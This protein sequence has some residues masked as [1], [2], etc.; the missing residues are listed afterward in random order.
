MARRVL[1]FVL[2]SMAIAAAAGALFAGVISA[3]RGVVEKISPDGKTLTVKFARAEGT[4]DLSVA[5][6]IDVL[7]DGKHVALTAIKPGMSVT[8]QVDG[9]VAQRIIA[10]AASDAEPKTT[11]PPKPKST[12]KTTTTRKSKQLARKSSKSSSKKNEPNALDDLPVA[13]T[14]LAGLQNT[15][16]GKRNGPS[17]LDS[18][19][20]ATTPLAGL[21]NAPGG[22]KNGPSALDSLPV[23]ATPLA[24]SK[25]P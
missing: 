18:L 13:T 8:V 5:G 15:P 10:H 23:A 25:S 14:P 17:A 6:E 22:K 2:T 1:F 3:K 20:V 4:T 19:P 11:K 12:A 24:G 9:T 21:Q 7:L 16:G